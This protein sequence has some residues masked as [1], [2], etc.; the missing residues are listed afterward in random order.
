MSIF[1]PGLANWISRQVGL[2]EENK[3]FL[4]RLIIAELVE[5]MSWLVEK[6]LQLVWK[7]EQLLHPLIQL[8]KLIAVRPR[9]PITFLF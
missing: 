3:G 8:I 1:G 9:M 2:V 5:K 4:H 6:A 7:R